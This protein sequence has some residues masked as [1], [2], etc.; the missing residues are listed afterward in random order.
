MIISKL[1]DLPTLLEP[2]TLLKNYDC[3]SI[4]FRPPVIV[5]PCHPGPMAFSPMVKPVL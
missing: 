5:M 4:S 1:W 2:M 3:D